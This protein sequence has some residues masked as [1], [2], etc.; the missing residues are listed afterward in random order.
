MTEYLPSF[1]VEPVLRQA[2]R[3]SRLSGTEDSASFLPAVPESIRTWTPAR[4][5]STSPPPSLTEDE[6]QQEGT[7]QQLRRNIQ[8]WTNQIPSPPLEPMEVTRPEE[9][10][11]TNN[12]SVT[13][14]PTLDLQYD[15]S[16]PVRLDET[17]TNSETSLNPSRELSDRSRIFEDNARSHSH[18][19]PV[20][21]RRSRRQTGANDSTTTAYGNQAEQYRRRD[22]SGVLPEDDGMGPLRQR[23]NAV[24][25][26][27]GSPAEKSRLIHTLMMERYR[28]SQARS[29]LATAKASGVPTERPQSPISVIS[30]ASQEAV[31]NLT[32]SD[33]TPT[34][35]R[36]RPSSPNEGEGDE[37]PEEY[38]PELGCP[39]Y[40]RNVKMQCNNCERWYP[41]RLCHDEVE[42]HILPRRQTKHMLCML[43]N[44][45]QPVSQTCK[46]CGKLAASYY[47]SICKLWS[48]DPNKSI[49][50]CDDC[51]ICRLGQGLGKDFFHCK[52]C[53]ACMSIQ[54]EPTHKCIEKSTQ[55]DCP[56]CGEYLFTSNK[57]V[58]FMRCGHSIHQSCFNDWCQT[59]YKCP[60]CSK[61]IANMEAQF[62]RLERHI[63]E[64]PMPEEYRSTRA[65]I[66]CN[67][68][69]SRSTTK[70]HWLGLKCERC[71]SYNTAQL[72]LLGPTDVP[73]TPIHAE[74]SVN[75][76]TAPSRE[77][78]LD[79][80][81]SPVNQA[82]HA[83]RSPI[84]EPNLLPR[85]PG[86]RSLSPAVGSYFGTGVQPLP[87]RGTPMEDDEDLDFWGGQSPRSPLSL[88]DVQEEE[89]EEGSEERSSSS[90]EVMEEEDDEAEDEEEDELDIFGHR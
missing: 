76:E 75:S 53:A 35:V 52:T 11:P 69:S 68:C 41:C 90:D 30:G 36:R 54:A 29:A 64:Q 61:S 31:F 62:R 4:F 87:R 21:G 58:A 89:D 39:H 50:H 66:F 40:K 57:S 32:P 59:S 67:D 20:A 17:R 19:D 81:T 80:E 1:I 15:Q 14:F 84:P 78:P 34:F 73:S 10:L 26:G 33:L 2:R 25:S 56:I 88:Q 23:I 28:L 43:C 16:R 24:W 3:F 72:Q 49:Y 83:R 44:T 63:S 77:Q 13:Q 42:D 9:D 18:S 22:G 37:H 6:H 60:I 5:W 86:A 85:S 51:G 27:D 79:T 48:D 38:G 55:C 46:M 82:Q 70:Y 71:D 45:P 12:P 8:L 7:F 65:Y 47:C 74:P